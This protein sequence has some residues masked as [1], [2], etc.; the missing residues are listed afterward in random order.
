MIKFNIK[1]NI[2]HQSFNSDKW[3]NQKVYIEC[4]F[5]RKQTNSSLE[6]KIGEYN[7]PQ[8]VWFKNLGSIIQNDR[9]IVGDINHKIQT[10]G[11][12]S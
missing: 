9:E 1:S 2:Y 5:S 10:C 3:H 11:W 8:V 4:K 7:K 12:N 6:M